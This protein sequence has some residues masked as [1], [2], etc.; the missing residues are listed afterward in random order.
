MRVTAWRGE[1]K[2]KIA[3]RGFEE[4]TTVRT[5]QIQRKKLCTGQF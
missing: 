5:K 3:E 1:E 2:K 4:K